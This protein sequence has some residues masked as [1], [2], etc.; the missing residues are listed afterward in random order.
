[1]LYNF[2]EKKITF[3]LYALIDITLLPGAFFNL[4]FLDYF[5]TTTSAVIRQHNVRNKHNTDPGQTTLTLMSL[6][7]SFYLYRSGTLITL[8]HL[9]PTTFLYLTVGMLAKFTLPLW[10][11]SALGATSF[12]INA[13]LIGAVSLISTALGIC[14]SF[15]N[16]TSHS[17]SQNLTTF[18]SRTM[19]PAPLPSYNP[20]YRPMIRQPE[21]GS[22]RKL[23]SH[24]PP[25]RQH[26]AESTD[27]YDGV[28]VPSA[29]PEPLYPAVNGYTDAPPSYGQ[30]CNGNSYSSPGYAQR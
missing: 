27:Q 30:A 12:F 14:H 11:I 19:V 4:F 7:L 13:G 5:F 20:D 24:F 6:A 18:N 15:I 10:T 28:V 2:K 26:D 23:Q 17:S 21:A 9:P 1:M 8:A 22:T 3:L 16:K 25:N 29:P